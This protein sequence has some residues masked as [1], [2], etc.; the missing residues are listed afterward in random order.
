MQ[1]DY[2]LTYDES[3]PSCL[4]WK[5]PLSNRN[6]V[7]SVAGSLNKHLGYWQIIVNGKRTYNHIVI[8]EM[9]GIYKE[10]LQVDHINRDRSDNRRENLRA[11]T[12]ADNLLNK[13][14]RADN[15]SGHTGVVWNKRK[16]KW[17]SSI[18]VN[19]VTMS[20]GYHDKLDDAVSAR[21][22]QAKV[23]GYAA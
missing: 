2:F 22:E 19:K 10:G 12:Q 7:G 20:L 21:L 5:N 23:V 16:Q 3:S 4:R 1:L 9:F 15:T 18:T 13:S 6:K 17:H 8:A 14:K 11:V